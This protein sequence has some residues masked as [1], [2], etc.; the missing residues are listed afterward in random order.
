[1]V[2]SLELSCEGNDY[3]AGQRKG[4]GMACCECGEGEWNCQGQGQI[5]HK[6]YE[7][8][9]TTPYLFALTQQ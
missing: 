6:Q 7:E 5:H 2:I 1:M 4:M 9:E 8:E 3:Y